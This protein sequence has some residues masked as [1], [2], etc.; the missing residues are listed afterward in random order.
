VEAYQNEQMSTAIDAPNVWNGS[1][2]VFA[3]LVERT[4]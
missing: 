3:A 4:A 1:A 2:R